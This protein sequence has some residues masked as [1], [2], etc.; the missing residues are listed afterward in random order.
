[1]L[2]LNILLDVLQQ[3]ELHYEDFALIL[4]VVLEG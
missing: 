2:D 4:S 3:R 1:M